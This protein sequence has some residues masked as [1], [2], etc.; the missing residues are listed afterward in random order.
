VKKFV[1]YFLSI[2]ICCKAW[3]KTT[4]RAS[5]NCVFDS[6]KQKAINSLN[7]DSFSLILHLMA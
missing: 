3:C 6:K 5:I 2:F 4:E 7:A 1:V